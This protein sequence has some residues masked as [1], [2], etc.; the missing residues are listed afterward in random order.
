MCVWAEKIASLPLFFVKF[1]VSAQKIIVALQKVYIINELMRGVYL[2]IH[3]SKKMVESFQ[4]VA[5]HVPQGRP[6]ERSTGCPRGPRRRD[7][8]RTGRRVRIV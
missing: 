2:L 8:A 3:K 6:R 5:Q 1:S 7:S 4:N